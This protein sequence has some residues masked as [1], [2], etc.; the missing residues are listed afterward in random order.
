MKYCKNEL[1]LESVSVVSNGSKITEK[2]F[3]KYGEFLDI[4]AVSCD[5]FN[6]KTNIEIGRGKG[7]HCSK[8]PDINSWCYH[9]SI[10]FKLHSV[11]NK[12]NWE[13]DM[14]VHIREL[15]PVRWKC[16][17]VLLL[18]GE[19]SGN[20]D[21]RDAHRF[22]ITDDQFQ[23]FL[24]RHKQQKC[25][26]PENNEDMKD[27]YLILDEDMCFLNCTDGSKLPSQSIF[28][29]GVEEALKQSGFDKNTFIK[30]GAI[31]DWVAEKTNCSKYD[32]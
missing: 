19:N 11:I 8:L 31:Y 10:Q 29:V 20:D 32:F 25:I 21:L 3:K 2:W 24:L 4:L 22:L 1:K 28:E 16:F 6:E 23:S 5:S 17:Q 12:Y 15:N 9:Y 13:E 7:E 18:K 30:R 26:V 27:S 14:N